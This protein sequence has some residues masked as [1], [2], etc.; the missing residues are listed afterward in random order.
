MQ[1]SEILFLVGPTAAG[2]TL[3]GLHL[4]R[5]INAEIIS[6]DSMQ[7]YKGTDI[8]TSK[9][10]SALRKKIKHHLISIVSPEKEY[11]VARYYRDALKKIKEIIK[12]GRTPLFVGGTGLYLSILLDGIFKL[13]TENKIIR[14]K[15]Y[16]EAGL[17]GSGY[18]Y[19]RLKEVDPEAALKIHP[20]D[21]RRIVR[22]LEVF[23]ATGKPISQLQKERKGLIDEYAI[24]IFCLNMERDKLYRRIEKRIDTM[25]NQ[26]LLAEVRRL[27]KLK[28]SKTAQPAIGI[29]ELK[30]YFADFY[31]LDK[32]KS[33]MKKNTRNYAKRQLTWFRKD[34]RI[35]WLE[36]RD[37]ETPASV[38]AR[39]FKILFEPSLVSR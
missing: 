6:C 20:N 14:R 37:K 18:L 38:A 3:T 9:P 39:I 2:K 11:N 32:A 10:P 21:T 13:S 16:E 5:K 28:L 23:E 22:A 36:V 17:K 12:K 30:G 35:E 15:L 26:G 34:K 7:I 24:R 19:K 8:I 27:L 33:L 25:F 1:K 29:K 4:A 31:D